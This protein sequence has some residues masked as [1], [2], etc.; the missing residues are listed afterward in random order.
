MHLENT[1]ILL[2]SISIY[3]ANCI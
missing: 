1:Y 3:Y 2:Y